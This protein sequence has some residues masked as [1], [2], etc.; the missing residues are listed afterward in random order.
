[1]AGVAEKHLVLGAL[2]EDKIGAV[3]VDGFDF[4]F[5]A[6]GDDDMVD[7]VEPHGL[8]GLPDALCQPVVVLAGVYVARGV[9]V[10]QCNDGGVAEQ[11]LFHDDA[12][13]DGCLGDAA[14]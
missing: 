10:A 7:Q 6:V 9:V 1:M 2:V 12:Y 13:V 3:C 14:V 5:F 4:D 11:C 8:A